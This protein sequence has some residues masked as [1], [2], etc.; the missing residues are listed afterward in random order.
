MNGH[1]P[2][3]MKVQGFMEEIMHLEGIIAGFLISKEGHIMGRSHEGQNS[4]QLLGAMSATMY[5]TAEAAASII[6]LHH[7]DIVEAV[8]KDGTILVKD[9]GKNALITVVAR[10]SADCPGLRESL[11][12][13]ARRIGEEI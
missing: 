1:P 7:P 13:I 5:A 3:N 11:S 6:H 2:L 10:S 8:A 9:A 4:A 12:R